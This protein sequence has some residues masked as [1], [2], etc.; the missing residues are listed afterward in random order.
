MEMNIQTSLIGLS[1]TVEEVSP[2]NCSS[3]PDVSNYVLGAGHADNQPDNWISF[4]NGRP[5][6]TYSIFGQP[7]REIKI[8]TSLIMAMKHRE[9]LL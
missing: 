5:Q 2:L 6:K 3:K 8:N 7:I 9:A 1:T 4:F